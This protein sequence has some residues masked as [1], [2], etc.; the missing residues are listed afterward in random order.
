MLNRIFYKILF[1]LLLNS[2]VIAQPNL[3]FEYDYAI[4]RDEG[5]KVYLELYYAFPSAE[6]VF[7]KN[8]TGY[9]ASGKLQ[10]DVINKTT[11]KTIVAKDFKIP[12][13][14]ADTSGS[15]KDFKLTGQI[16]L[17]LDSGT[18]LFKM[19]ASDFN[20]SSK[21][22]SA[23]EEILL[24]PFQDGKLMMSTIELSTGITKSADE[25]SLFYK[26]TLEVTPNPGNLFGNNLSKL[27]YYLELYNLNKQDLGD[28]YS[29]SVTIANKDGS[30]IKTNTKKYEV[31]S[32]SKVEYGSVDITGLPSNSYQLFVKLLDSK[33][34]ELL[35]AYKYFYVFSSDTNTVS[36]QLTDIENEYLLSE[37]AKM[38]EKQVDEE[39]NKAIYLM[40]DQQKE[41]YETL[42]TLD[43][44][45]MYMFKY[46]KGI[47]QYITKKEYF[48]R[49]D[50]ANKNF[51]SDLRE[52]W[53]TDRGRIY[54]IYGKYDEIERFPYEGS[55]RAYEI[56]TYNKL[57]GGVIFVFMDNSSGFGDYV[58]IHSTAQN[59][60]SDD[61]WRE[62][63]NI[64]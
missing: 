14:V 60:P 23:E 7:I 5:T 22:N 44:K 9:E 45:R 43:E 1:F 16:N 48:S 4:F 49:L 63:L 12:V 55:T 59:E 37:Y 20:E 42:K 64:R 2:A 18:Y 26:N 29:V 21:T 24:K 19:N 50:F 61:N 35:R 39:F 28:N 62:K 46:W 36:Q 25:G 17:L 3:S 51:K 58:Q 38:S 8:S 15:G 11:G 33:D 34:K 53:K 6:L 13:I 57:Q 56:W 10:L 41:R 52:G 32:E 40:S 30:E 31:K 54:A 27:F 47:A